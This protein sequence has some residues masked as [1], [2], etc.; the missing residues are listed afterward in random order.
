LERTVTARL[1]IQYAWLIAPVTFVV[2]LVTAGI[3]ATPG[4]LIV[5]L[6]TEFHWSRTAISAAIAVNIALFGLIGPFAA[7]VMDR[8]GVRRVILASL[9]LVATAV[10]LTT[11]MRS[12]WQLTLLW[13]VLVGSGTGVTS[14]VLAAV[15]ATRW[16]EE[17]RGLV[18]GA[19]SAANATGQLVFLPL[20]ARQI[21]RYGWRSAALIV[22]VVAAVVFAI[23]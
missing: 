10:S 6:E 7:S 9:A 1:W 17:R 18:M 23:V 15:I 21:E 3:R 14:M 5:P 16:F 20:L 12:E 8:W 13:G 11:Q 2:L 22:A 19:L 4:V